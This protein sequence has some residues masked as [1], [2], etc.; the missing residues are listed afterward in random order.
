MKKE[1]VLA[2]LFVSV[3]IIANTADA[4]PYS[5]VHQAEHR[6]A[7]DANIPPPGY[8][9]DELMLTFHHLDTKLMLTFHHLDTL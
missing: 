6:R 8:T 7:A 3:V 1:A 5:P 4:R 2:L 9:A